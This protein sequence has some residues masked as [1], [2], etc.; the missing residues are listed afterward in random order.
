MKLQFNKNK[1]S[2]GFTS[3]SEVQ[4]TKIKGGK[5]DIDSTN[6]ICGNSGNCNGSTNTTQCEG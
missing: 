1:L 4:L 5:K 2:G 6:N 3:L